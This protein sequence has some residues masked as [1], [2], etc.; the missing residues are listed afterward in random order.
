MVFNSIPKPSVKGRHGDV[1]SLQL[2]FKCR[3]KLASSV[4]KFANVAMI[5]NN[6]II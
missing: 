2:L 4:H 5:S 3:R 1:K 6:R